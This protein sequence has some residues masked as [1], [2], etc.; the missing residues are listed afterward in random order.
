MVCSGKKQH[1]S[2]HESYFMQEDGS[3]YIQGDAST[4]L[5]FFLIYDLPVGRGRS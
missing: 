1:S 4:Q 2:R 5:F 3:Y